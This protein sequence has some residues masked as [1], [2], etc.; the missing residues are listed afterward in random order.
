MQIYT[1]IIM[2]SHAPYDHAQ[3]CKQLRTLHLN[4]NLKANMAGTNINNSYTNNDLPFLC[5]PHR[6]VAYPG[7]WMGGGGGLLPSYHTL[8]LL[9]GVFKLIYAV[10][11]GFHVKKGV[12]GTRGPPRIRYWNWANSKKQLSSPL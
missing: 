9:R 5:T 3:V 1:V 7:H 10:M 12:H 4:Q 11:G 8:F 6:Q 2:Y